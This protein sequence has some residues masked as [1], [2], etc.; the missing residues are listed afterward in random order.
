MMMMAYDSKC[1]IFFALKGKGCQTAM[2]DKK[3]ND[4]TDD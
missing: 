4:P 3:R 2:E 1:Q